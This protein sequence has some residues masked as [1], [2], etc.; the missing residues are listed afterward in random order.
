MKKEQSLQE[1]A[2]STMSR[3]HADYARLL[4][5]SPL[6]VEALISPDN[7]RFDRFCRE[8]SAHPDSEELKMRIQEFGEASGCWLPGAKHHISCALYLYPGADTYRM[9]CMMQNLTLG[10][11]LNDVMG[12]DT[13]QYLPVEQQVSAREMILR[14]SRLDASL[15]VGVDAAPLE[16]VNAGI[17]QA[18]RDHSPRDWFQRFL[19]VYCYHIGITHTDGNVVAQGR[20]PG[21]TEYMDYRCH[22]GGVHHILQWIE[23]SDGQFLDWEKL[24][25]YGLADPLRR[26]HW[27]TAAFAGLSNDLFSFE[28][29]VI[30]NGSDSNLVMVIA[31]NEEG[32]P[33]QDAIGQA[34]GIVKALLMEVLS[35]LDLL[36]AGIDGLI[37]PDPQLATQ[38][39]SHRA[40]IVRCVQAI[41][42]WHC[43]S[44]RY[45]RPLSLWAETRL[46]GAK[47]ASWAAGANSAAVFSDKG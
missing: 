31:L 36:E 18:F 41:W 30:D 39:R 23:F 11:Y 10:F 26:L 43:Y 34:A 21:V 3:M 20:I 8:F 24:G 47:P 6:S 14:M 5:G 33:L 29:E 2:F 25:R 46:A 45:K 12:R 35:L 32:V 15:D 17:L 44:G 1:K 16:R 37:L 13:F 7:F 28:K 19:D 27:V 22:L 40:G 9:F 38:L 42:L 4:S